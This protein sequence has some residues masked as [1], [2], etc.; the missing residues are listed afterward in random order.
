MIKDQYSD[1]IIWYDQAVHSAIVALDDKY[2]NAIPIFGG[3]L[4]AYNCIERGD[5][6]GF[7]G[8]F[9]DLIDSA[10]FFKWH[11][12][13]ATVLRR[14]CHLCFVDPVIIEVYLGR[15]FHQ[16]EQDYQ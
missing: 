2:G 6:A 4:G 8:Y 13:T 3:A 7:V 11:E 9:P 15:T 5:I 10:K 16:I 12:N 14:F 1:D